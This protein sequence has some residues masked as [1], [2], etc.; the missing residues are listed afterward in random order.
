M[1][2]MILAAGRGERM[3]P[4][5]DELPKPLLAAG[6]SPLI[7]W[8]LRRLVRAGIRDVVINHAW[9]GDKIEARLG[10][11]EAFGVRIRYSAEGVALETAGGIA[12]ALPLLTSTAPRAD[13]VPDRRTDEALGASMPFLVISGD[14]FCD[15]DYAR[16]HT[17]ALQMQYARLACWCVMVT[18]PPHHGA[19]D[20]RL[21]DG[22]LA[23]AGSG[24]RLTYSGI[25]LY[26]PS[27]FDGVAPG[28]KSPLRPWL[29]QEIAAGRAAGEYHGGL[30]FDIG[31]AERLA[32]LDRLL[33]SRS[34]N[35]GV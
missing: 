10:N 33:E 31:T 27:L 9:L 28:Q 3:R 12:R 1:K 19:G 16:A 26:A 22:L 25:G 32:E 34:I 15:F 5:T 6:G 2:A 17:I 29:E 24:D 14:T 30:W 35:V 4:L 23:S 18:N 11:G 8:H 7:V 13:R 21:T 20:F